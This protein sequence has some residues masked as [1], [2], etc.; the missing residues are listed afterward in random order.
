MA[1]ITL[2][3]YALRLGKNPTVI[4]QKAIRGGFQS[5]VKMGR[6]WFIEED[7]PYVD[8]RFTSG[9]YCNWRKKKIDGGDKHGENIP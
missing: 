1:M 4:R 6:D 9:K 2:K 7:E 5:A 3:D 8:N